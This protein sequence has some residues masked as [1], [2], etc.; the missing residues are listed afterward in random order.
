MILFRL[1]SSTESSLEPKVDVGGALCQRLRPFFVNVGHAFGWQCRRFM[2]AISSQLVYALNVF[3]LPLQRH[4][5]TMA[6]Q[7]IFVG[8][9]FGY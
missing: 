9:A 2:S 3:V 4:W 1:P 5:L 6:A 7:L 8:S